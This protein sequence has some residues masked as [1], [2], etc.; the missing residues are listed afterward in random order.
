[1]WFYYYILIFLSW[2]VNINS[3]QKFLM[4]WCESLT[5]ILSLN[6]IFYIVWKLKLPLRF[7][8]CPSACSSEAGFNLSWD[9][10]FRSKNL[11]CH[12]HCELPRKGAFLP[13]TPK[14]IALV[15]CLQ[16][17]AF[18]I[19]SVNLWLLMFF[20]KLW[21]FLS[22]IQEVLADCC[23]TEAGKSKSILVYWVTPILRAMESVSILCSSISVAVV[24]TQKSTIKFLVEISA[25]CKLSH[26]WKCQWYVMSILSATTGSLHYLWHTDS[27]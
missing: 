8:S 14:L 17:W 1:M 16:C 10:A 21:C 22:E 13:I 24:C 4:F 25:C 23:W 11:L 6:C 20:W 7:E 3:T 27:C 12:R 19:R 5:C 26:N 2:R 15:Q 18:W 9:C